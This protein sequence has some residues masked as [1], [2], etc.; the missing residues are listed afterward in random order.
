M[1][2]KL[3]C[4]KQKLL[5]ILAFVF[6]INSIAY[7]QKN[8]Q[9]EILWDN[10]GVPH[11]FAVS[12]PEMFYA[13]GY[14]QM[15]NHADLILKLYGQARGKGA[16]YWGK[17]FL[18]TDKTVHLFG[19]HEK[20]AVL[21]Q[22]Q[23]SEIQNCLDAF[24]KGMNDWANANRE[25]IT[26]KY[27][28]VLPVTVNDVLLHTLRIIYLEFIAG[29]DLQTIASQAGTGSNA[30]AVAP[31]KSAS[32]NALLLIN[33]HLPWYDY[34]IWFE[35]HL[36]FPGNSIYGV[37]LVG[38]PSVSQAFNKNLGW[39][40]TINPIDI[41]DRYELL[42]KDGGYVLDGKTHAFKTKQVEIK[43]RQSDGNVTT[44]KYEFLYSEHGPVVA[45]N[46]EKAYAVRISGIENSGLIEEYLKMGKAKDFKEF[47]SALKMM[48]IPMFN[49]IYAD[50]VGNIFYLFNGNVPVRNEGDFGFWKGTIDGTQSK[51]IWNKTHDYT[52]LP[53]LLNPSTGFIQNCND[54]PWSCTYPFVLKPEDY[55]AY[56]SSGS[57]TL[58]PQ[59][60]VNMLKDDKA[61][62]FGKLVEYKHNTEMESALRFTDDL[63]RAVENHP[64]SL[65]LQ[66]AAVLKKWDMKTETTS[67]G[68]VL[69]AAWWD[70]VKSDMFK[71]PWNKAEPVST[72][73]GLKDEKLAVELLVKAAQETVKKYGALDIEWGEVHRFAAGN[74][75]YPANGGPGD[76]YG[77][78][79]TI[80]FTDIAG[81]KK[82]AV[83]GETFIA[84]VEF[85]SPQK[86]MVSLSYGNATQPGNKHAGD[87]LADL[88]A[89]KLRPALLT[90]DQV[91]QNLEKRE[92]IDFKK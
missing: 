63:L 38:T 37:G 4:H 50:K 56:M 42:L 8:K 25:L 70:K 51:F 7:G 78:F 32:K 28:L 6:L 15:N 90:H 77:L 81:N 61:I 11:I 59:R 46:S 49:I 5:N 71:T 30:I 24:A 87:Q 47:E 10:F 72:P 76:H 48:Q 65:A 82:A 13:Y 73:D 58:R 92:I 14:A 29:E 85:G 17:E 91:L 84:V 88:S 86:A 12:E 57:F 26:E 75:N 35:S 54:A 64:D 19:L 52:D 31:S 45:Q 53:K 55:P 22:K 40:H 66:A 36:N 18:N 62:T 74:L 9:T 39:A 69:F 41:S 34:F 44:G 68:A 33:P 43:V 79:R 27:R 20:S 80:Y 60:A 1:K 3:S 23:S 2:L 16:E 67:K 83:A 89:K 21:Y